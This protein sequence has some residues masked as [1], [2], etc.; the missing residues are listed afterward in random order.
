MN[1]IDLLRKR[2]ANIPKEI[3]A[4]NYQIEQLRKKIHSLRSERVVI[5]YILQQKQTQRE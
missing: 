3:N 1:K 4:C 2:R 5:D